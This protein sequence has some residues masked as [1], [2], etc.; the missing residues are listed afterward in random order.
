ME[1]LVN[2]D[3]NNNNGMNVLSIC[4]GKGFWIKSSDGLLVVMR[5]CGPWFSYDIDVASR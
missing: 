1:G 5:S 4:F 3:G 2:D